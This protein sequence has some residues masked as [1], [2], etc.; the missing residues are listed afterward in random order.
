MGLAAKLCLI[1]DDEA[2]RAERLRVDIDTS[3]RELG[4]TGNDVRVHNLSTHGFMTEADELYPVGAYVW[5]RLP[6]VGRVNAQ[7]IWRDCFRYGCG[8]VTPLDSEQWAAAIA[9]DEPAEDL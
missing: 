8:F 9:A 3:M 5:L 2:R 7:I 6:G 4:A 1:Q